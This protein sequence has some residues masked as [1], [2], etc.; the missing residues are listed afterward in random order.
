VHL[1]LDIK[2]GGRLGHER[3]VRPTDRYA[4]TPR[5]IV[6]VRTSRTCVSSAR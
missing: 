4:A 3:V 6:G 1:L 2:Q 5:V